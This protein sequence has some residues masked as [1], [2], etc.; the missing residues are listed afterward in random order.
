LGALYAGEQGWHDGVLLLVGQEISPRTHHYLA[1]AL[2]E[3]IPG[4]DRIDY[5]NYVTEVNERG[6]FGIIAHPYGGRKPPFFREKGHAWKDWGITGFTGIEIWSYMVDWVDRVNPLSLPYYYLFPEKAIR[7][8][9]PEALQK[10]DEIA[11]RRHIVGIGGVDAHA[12]QLPLF[13]FI[14]VFPYEY[15]FRTVRTHI[16]LETPLSP[17]SLEESKAQVYGALKRGRCFFAY[18]LLADSMGFMFSCAM[19]DGTQLVM[20]DETTFVESA[21]LFA[22]VPQPA[23]I[24]LICD[25][26]TIAETQGKSLNHTVRQAG[27]YRVEADYKSQP[28]IFSNPIF[29][30][31]A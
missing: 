31:N 17:P 19:Q 15:L 8:P 10:W 16:L 7:G 12:K 28:W 6:G 20:G 24:R 22:S 9:R 3:E 11:Q 29:L 26:V 23:T 4:V 1:F 14:K 21:E 27:V 25:G 18:D 5:Q 2:D 13:R 30:R